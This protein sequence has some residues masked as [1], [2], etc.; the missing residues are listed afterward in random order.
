MGNLRDESKLRNMQPTDVVLGADKDGCLVN[1]PPDNFS[2]SIPITIDTET[3]DG[4]E[5]FTE[6]EVNSFLFKKIKSEDESIEFTTDT[7]GNIDASVNFPTPPTVD[8]PVTGAENVKTDDNAV[9]IY[10]QLSV[11][12]IQLKSL[13]SE[14]II[15]S[16]DGDDIRFSLAGGGSVSNDWYLD[17]NF[18]R[19]TNWGQSQNPKESITYLSSMAMINPAIYTNG[20]VVK[21]PSGT[22][23]DPFKTYE[24]YLLKRIYG[25]GGSGTGTPSKHNPKYPTK[26]LQ[27]LSNISTSSDLEVINTIFYIKNFSTVT[28]TGVR[29][30]AFDY[31]TI[32]D[33]LTIS[34]NLQI[35]VD[36]TI[37]GEGTIT[38]ANNFG[39]IYSKTDSTKTSNG[40]FCTL[41]LQP[42]G[43]GLYFV[44]GNNTV[45][46]APLTKNGGGDLKYGNNTVL[47]ANQPP[48]T[49]LIVIEGTNYNSWNTFLTGTSLFL[50]T[51]TQIGVRY[52]NDGKI[53][54]SLYTLIYQVGNNKI[55][56]ETRLDNTS[57][58]VNQ[59]IVDF[60]ETTTNGKVYYKP[61]STYCMFRGEDTS[62]FRIE[63]LSTFPNGFM[64]SGMDS[65]ISLSG[66]ARFDQ[67]SEIKD[68]RGA[69]AL[70]FIKAVGNTT[71]QSF[72]TASIDSKYFNFVKGDGTNTIELVFKH[73]Q[74]DSKNISQ[75]V[76]LLN[77][78]TLGTL[79][80]IKRNPII[81]MNEYLDE[82]QAK[83]LGG[84]VTGMIFKT[85]VTHEIV[86]V[87]NP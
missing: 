2:G 80:T 21:V 1:F 17:V 25:A 16:E 66:S 45:A 76:A 69:P 38:S 84:L 63:N 7:D 24:E 19:P 11:K 74:I 70:N 13:V 56:Y 72:N 6:P 15:I 78:T 22:L 37:K 20:Q 41:F 75:D 42:E 49:P 4:E 26:T 58:G 28:Y 59:Q 64:H 68:V 52:F 65:I 34:G 86:N 5:L 30:Y 61:Y 87:T 29:Q 77:I 47:G 31:R 67:I 27:I 3:G 44:E 43:K 62:V 36:N 12:K 33:A 71:I 55:G 40:T 81:T 18:Q 35:A 10:K 8:Y 79:S 39:L 14:D 83:S 57:T 32:F 54:S 23:N 53:T 46:Y 48:V 73:S 60:Y 85:S 50:Q 9:G 51:N 82:A